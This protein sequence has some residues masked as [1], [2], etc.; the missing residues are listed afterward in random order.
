VTIATSSNTATVLGNGITTAFAFGFYV[1]AATDLIVTYTNALG[2]STTLSPSQYV[3]TGIGSPAGGTVIY[4]LVGAPI[5]TGTKVTIQRIVPYTQ[6][7]ALAGQG[8]YFPQAVESALDNLEMQIQQLANQVTAGV[9]AV[10]SVNGRTGAVTLISTDIANALGFTPLGPNLTGPITSVGNATAVASQTGTGT[11]FAMQASPNFT[12]APLAP[13]AAPGT[14]TTQLATTAFVAAAVSGAVSGVASFNTRTGA[15]TLTSADVTGA[16]AFTPLGP[17]LTGPITSSGNATAIAAQTGTGSVFVVQTSPALA[18]T[19][20]A[21]TAAFGTN[22]TQIAS[23]AF[24]QSAVVSSVSGVASFNTRSGA[25]TLTA[26]DVSSVLNLTGPITTTAGMATSIASQTGTG[27]TFAMQA[28]PTFTGIPAAPTAAVNTNTTQIATT[29]F[30]MAQLGVPVSWTPVITPATG[31]I[32][33]Q[34]G[35]GSYARIGLNIYFVAIDITINNAGTAAGSTV[36]SIN[37]P[38]T[39]GFA[40]QYLI[41]RE[42]AVTGLVY[43]GEARISQASFVVASY[44]NGTA[45]IQTGY[46]YTFTGPLFSV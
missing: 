10:N 4:P 8:G 46:R 21:P 40:R 17:N 35:L 7:T 45:P 9:S 36:F 27:T 22:T 16:L 30:V 26:A 32:T 13:T 29:A 15:V 6:P 24:V 1:P 23:T 33:T 34:T 20:T 5:A 12:D 38:F 37:L 43:V 14:N 2:V 41:G 39:N 28:G 3:A 11:T 31:T 44:I 19:P 18:G 25:V 42:S